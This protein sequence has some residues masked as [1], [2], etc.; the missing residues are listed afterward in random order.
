MYFKVYTA[1][2]SAQQ[3]FIVELE[4]AIT[5]GLPCINIVGLPDRA[6]KESKSRV[7]SALINS[8]YKFPL[9]KVTINMLPGLKQKEGTSHEAAMAVAIMGASGF[10]DVSYEAFFENT[11]ILGELD[12]KGGL[13]RVRG[14]NNLLLLAEKN[15]FTN[16]IIP[17]NNF[18]NLDYNGS[19]NIISSESIKYLLEYI[20]YNKVPGKKRSI[21]RMN[22][23]RRV[24]NYDAQTEELIY[25]YG[26]FSEIKGQK[27]AKYQALIS[28][29]GGH[30]FLIS[31]PPGCGKTMMATRMAAIMPELSEKTY[32]ELL[33]LYEMNDNNSTEDLVKIKKGIRPF[34][35][36]H[37]SCTLNS[38]VG[39]GAYALPGEV[40]YSH[41][42]I[43][44]LDEACE[45]HRET[46][47]C[48]R[49]PLTSREI[50]ISRT[51]MRA[52]YPCDF[53]FVA[54]TNLCPCGARED[55]EGLCICS[56][57]AI[58][59]Y[60]SRLS[61][62]LLDRFDLVCLMKK[63][64]SSQAG[65]S[66][67]P[68][69]SS[70]EM[71]KFV[72]KIRN[73]QSNRY[74]AQDRNNSNVDDR[75]FWMC[76][77]ISPSILSIWRDMSGKRGFNKRTAIRILRLARTLSDMKGTRKIETMSMKEAFFIN[78]S[79]GHFQI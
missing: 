17:E 4:T 9:R 59:N 49:Q 69:Q 73:I 14:I 40:A 26:D 58:R 79:K 71:R 62:A 12:L 24:F 3:A 51:Y 63:S 7:K 31:G 53:I 6:V 54:A 13:R 67:F 27:S 64:G 23:T 75:Q 22:Q 50:V 72:S 39:G 30:N 57:T 37:Y 28:V 61:K 45:M 56:I 33:S 15:K 16:V 43:L 55:E 38:I 70:R 5:P 68:L 46:L 77:N 8:G 29:C 47:D 19:I 65:I 34:R 44:F 1:L 48:L 25:E 18:K 66:D 32:L 60:L 35:A 78:G 20:R 52:S 74:Q 21:K 41:G 10:F 11:I 76:N 36:P 42:G 2:Y